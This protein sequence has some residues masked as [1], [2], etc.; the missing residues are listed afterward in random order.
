MAMVSQT[1]IP[2]LLSF[3]VVVVVVAT[4]TVASIFILMCLELVVSA[5]KVIHIQ[6]FGVIFLFGQFYCHVERNMRFSSQVR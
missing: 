1:W 6:A 4:V 5:S 3:V 2:F